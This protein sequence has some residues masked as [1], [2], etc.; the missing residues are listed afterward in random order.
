MDSSS[1]S[2]NTSE[3]AKPRWSGFLGYLIALLTLTLP[4]W[5]IA[6]YSS[7]STAELIPRT[8]YSIPRPKN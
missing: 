7:D 6:Y 1:P 2:G 8:P 5:A 3:P 4:I